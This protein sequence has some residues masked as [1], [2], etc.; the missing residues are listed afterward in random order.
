MKPIGEQLQNFLKNSRL[1]NGL[2]AFEI[3]KIWEEIMGKT[4]A[5]YTDKI[6]LKDGVLYISTHVAPLKH[7]LHFQK[8][9]IAQ[10]IN[11]HLNDTIVK[12]VIVL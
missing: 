10:R 1:K 9:T 5:T 6:Q 2:Y 4:V 8:A 11:E 7:E 12:E 3:E